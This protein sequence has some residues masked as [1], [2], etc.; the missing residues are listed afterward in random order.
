MLELHVFLN[1]ALLSSKERTSCFRDYVTRMLVAIVANVLSIG[2]HA[3]RVSVHFMLLESTIESAH[4]FHWIAPPDRS[5]K[6]TRFL[7]YVIFDFLIRFTRKRIIR[8][9]TIVNCTRAWSSI[10]E[11]VCSGNVRSQQH[12]CVILRGR[13]LNRQNAQHNYLVSFSHAST[14]L[15]RNSWS[16]N[17]SPLD[18]AQH[19]FR[20]PS[21]TKLISE[22]FQKA[23]SIL[24]LP[25]LFS[26]TPIPRLF[27]LRA[28]SH[29]IF[30]LCHPAGKIYTARSQKVAALRD[31]KRLSGK[32]S[33]IEMETKIWIIRPKC[34]FVQ[35]HTRTRKSIEDRSC[36]GRS[37]F[38][39]NLKFNGSLG[40]DDKDKSKTDLNR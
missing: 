24:L 18:S 8:S 9:V 13:H 21:G 38:K 17:L 29:S 30:C 5:R 23:Q 15:L 26:L 34:S 36:E 14:E 31:K 35:T 11:T 27:P 10:I 25:P 7:I 32:L 6:S 19:A 3:P 16:S 33:L 40:T 1:L 4:S 28:Y 12:Q 22:G 2:V 39:L 37:T 20:V